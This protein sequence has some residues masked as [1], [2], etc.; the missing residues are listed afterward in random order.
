MS[1]I[2]VWRNSHRDPFVD[3]ESNSFLATYTSYQAAE[4]E[5]KSMVECNQKDPHF[6]DYQI[7]E[8]ANS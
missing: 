3:T 6:F 7:Y 5:A 1:Y 8:E 4:R 2:I